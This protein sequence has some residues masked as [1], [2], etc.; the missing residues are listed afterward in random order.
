MK[1]TAVVLPFLIVLLTLLVLAGCSTGA[2]SKPFP[3]RVQ[4][5]STLMKPN[6]KTQEDMENMI[7][8]MFRKILTNDLIVDSTGP[9]TKDGFRMVFRHSQAWEV[10]EGYVDV[11]HINVSESQGY[12][13]M[14]LAYMAGSEKKLNLSP[15]EWIYGCT[16]L[17]EYY[18]AMLRTVLYYPSIIAPH[19]FTWEL[20]G[21]P[22]DGD[23]TNGYT[24]VNG[25]N[26]APFTIDP[27]G[28][29]SATDGDMDIIYSL[30]LADQQWG[31]KGNYN[32][33]A[34]A[35]DMLAD[36]WT[37]C[38][39]DE[40]HTLLLGDWAK[41]AEDPI[42]QDATRPSDFIISHLKV[43]A[44]FDPSHDWQSVVDACYTVIKDIRDTQNSMGNTNGLIPDFAIR[45]D[46]GWEAPLEPILEGDD[47]SFAYNAC[48]VPWRLGTDYLLFGN[49]Q[50]GSSSLYDYIIKPMDDFARAYTKGN[51]EQFGPLQLDGTAF[52][53]TD[54]DLFAVPFLITAEANGADQQWV[55]T[56]WN[57]KPA[58]EGDFK[59]INEY[60]GDTYADY[61]KM[62]VMLTAS[63][64]Y[65]RP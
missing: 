22:K 35:L 13:M 7:I 44:T 45:G 6:D 58:Y 3:Q 65:W 52:D 10:D 28:G 2:P 16:N 29:D 50:I 43:Y 39:H 30:I 53:W 46:S 38:V 12:G 47:G 27:V 54:P 62:L 55:N 34:I 63:G 42:L 17:K 18:D 61:I 31:S 11:S 20:R 51:L 33:K 60:L 4:Y 14:I 15:E 5:A 49:S 1:K 32:Y 64:N 37:Y 36:F 9:R 26:V 48:R 41:G 57:Y 8:D 23:N 21:N 24:T 40:Y 19:L 59:G 56:F 25:V